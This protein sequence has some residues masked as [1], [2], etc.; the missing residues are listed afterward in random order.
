[1]R[2]KYLN[3]GLIGC[4]DV[5]ERKSG[6]SIL[7]SGR[8]HIT[9][10]MRRHPQKARAFCAAHG[11]LLCGD[12]PEEIINT[13]D[14]VYV[15]TPPS[16]HKDYAIQAASAGKHVLVEK[17]MGLSASEDRDMIDVC[18]TSGVKLFTAYYRRFHPHIQKMKELIGNGAL[19]EVVM[20][21]VDFASP[22]SDCQT[23]N[24]RFTPAISGGGLFVDVVS[25]RIDLLFYLIG[26]LVETAGTAILRDHGN[27]E[28]AAAG[29]ILFHNGA[30]ATV[31]GEFQSGQ[32][33]DCFSITG[34]K[35]RIHTDH[36]DSHCFTFEA[37][38]HRNDFQFAKDSYPHLGLIRHIE[39]IL[40]DGQAAAGPSETGLATDQVL[41]AILSR[42]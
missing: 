28:K 24:W 11:I 31:S 5:V 10:V 23:L 42:A 20:A 14:I 3:W 1:M 7:S 6:P 30:I 22:V 36:L 8:S 40:L 25:H 19:G 27:T 29:T 18:Q 15:A 32:H 21:H 17:P 9:G 41:D 12:D 4:G 16:S 39:N 13:C 38:G 34:T 33:R 2:K 26:D 37:D 35:G